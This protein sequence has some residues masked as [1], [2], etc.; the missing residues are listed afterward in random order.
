MTAPYD[1][2]ALAALRRH[3]FM[4]DAVEARL[5]REARMG[6]HRRRRPRLRVRTRATAPVTSV[7]T[8]RCVVPVCPVPEAVR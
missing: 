8:A 1:L 3:E 7:A 2:A 6:R 4:A 5:A